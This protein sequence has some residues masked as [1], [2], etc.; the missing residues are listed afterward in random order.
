VPPEDAGK[1][2]PRLMLVPF[3]RQQFDLLIEW[4]PNAEF[5]LQWAGS[6]LEYPLTRAQLQLLLETG[7]RKP[8]SC[9][10]FG[11]CDPRDGSIV[12]HGEIGQVDRRNHSAHLMRILLGPPQLRGRGLGGEIVRELAR[13]AF[14]KLAVH[15]LSLAVFERN[16][17]AIRCYERVGFRLEGTLRDAR[18]HGSEY[19]N[20]CLMAM[21]RP[22]WERR[23][24][25]PTG[26]DPER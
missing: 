26:S 10:L 14:E 15:R 21:L 19:W 1:R 12:G 4:T 18:C 8:P 13:F 5:L 11:V 17:V 20:L 25:T 23:E 7:A 3:S 9:Y 6:Q 16:A 2:G 22:E 24:A